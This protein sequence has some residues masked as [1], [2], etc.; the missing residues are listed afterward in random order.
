MNTD[1]GALEFQAYINNQFLFRTAKQAE[2]RIKGLADYA[3]NEAAKMDKS[4][5]GVGKTLALLGG[6]GAVS[7]LGEKI[8]ETTAKFEKFGIVLRNTLGE[9][10]GDSALAMLS[11]FAAK[12]PTQ[13]DEVTDSFIKMANQGFVPTQAE[14]IK[15]GDLSSSTGKGFGQLAEA[16]LDA[17]TNQF[18]RLKEFGITSSQ[19]QDKVTF[20]FKEQQTT[21]DKTATSIRAY[22]LSLGELNGVQGANAAI[23]ES[24][25]G[26][27]S[28]LEDRF[29][30]MYNQIGSANS[31]IIYTAIDGAST[32]VDNYEAV[33]QVVLSL[34]GIYGAYQAA[35]ITANAVSILQRE[36]A[37]QQMLAN[38]GNTGAMI[39]LTTAEGL[40]A[41]ASSAATRA[42]LALNASMLANPFVLA[43]VAV[44]SLVA[45]TYAI[46]SADSIAEQARASF[47]REQEAFSES[48]NKVSRETSSLTNIIK[49]NSSS[50][51]QQATA[52]KRLQEL[53]PDVL[54]NI[55]LHQ[56]KTMDA[57]KA[58]KEFNAAID[59]MSMANLRSQLSSF[60]TQ[61][62]DVQ[63]K[64]SAL[65]T[66]PQMGGG[67]AQYV[68]LASALER[69]R[70]ER[71]EYA[72]QINNTRRIERKANEE[73]I[74]EHQTV[75]VKNK[76]YWDAQL[77]KAKDALGK[78]DESQKGSKAWN[79]QV[80]LIKEAEGHL[81]SYSLKAAS[82]N[83]DTE[84]ITPFGTLE[85][86]NE[87]LR[88]LK[89]SVTAV[90]KVTGKVTGSTFDK[91]GK[92]TAKGVDISTEIKTA[93]AKIKELTVATKEVAIKTFDEELSYK[94]SQYEQYYMLIE[95]Y[96]IDIAKASFQSLLQ[97]GASLTS[98]LEGELLRLQAILKNGNATPEQVE[99]LTKLTTAL[100]T[101]KGVKDN[102]SI[103]NEEL[104]QIKESSKTTT[105]Y[106]EKLAAARIK[107]DSGK[108]NLTPE[109]K[110]KA[111][112]IIDKATTDSSKEALTS[113]LE[114]FKTTQTKMF[115]LEA[116]FNEDRKVLSKALSEAKTEDEK[117][118]IEAS[119]KALEV[120]YNKEKSQMSVENLMASTDWTT[121]FSD[122]DKVSV[123]K[124]IELKDK[125]EAQFKSLKLEPTDLASLR[126]KIDEVTDKIQ[127]KNPFKALS[128][129]I[130]KYKADKSEVNTKDL[131]G[132]IADSANAVK[133][134][135]DQITGSL[136]KLGVKTSEQTDVVLKD[137]SGMLGGAANL[138][139]GI[140]TGNPMAIIQGSIDLIMNGIDLIGGAA[141]RNL[142]AA[143]QQHAKE[144]V[145]LKDAYNELQRAID[146]ALGTDRYATQR[147]SIENLKKQQKEYMAMTVAEF[148]KKNTDDSKVKE[149]QDAY[150][151]ALNSIEDT[152]QKMREEILTM[153]VSSAANEL[154]NAL[155]SA[156]SA[157]EDAAKAWGAKVDDIVGN[158][159]KKML[160]QKLVEQ[161]VGAIINKY[162]STWVDSE[163]NFL[164][165]S[166]IIETAD[167]MG[168]DLKALG[169]GL[170]ASL[171]SLPDYIKN[172]LTGTPA[173]DNNTALSGAIQGVSQE[174]A[175]VISGQVNAMRIN[176]IEMKGILSAILI[177]SGRIEQNTANMVKL[178]DVVSI[179]K[180]ISNNN[181]LR[182]QG[183]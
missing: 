77:A 175:S 113:L 24:M 116:K 161:P 91:T 73:S 56:F 94:K 130:K 107:V 41:V 29:A 45:V 111:V 136:D 125:I 183:L 167:Q 36:I 177:S 13:L 14:M 182:S 134:T 166:N 83:K 152:I 118:Q 85:Y 1:N 119:S 49:D 86:W 114:K 52:F 51:L 72:L 22:L 150:K 82:V 146:S 54:K 121:L 160:I 138:A 117:R 47:R 157:G 7:M 43:T 139:M 126:S 168:A 178:N 141:D 31:G 18:E 95:N 144:V 176:Q 17:Q 10:A 84:K 124:L 147:D 103:F 169:D 132:S 140:A 99:Q 42:Q 89:E 137:V 30:A 171:G 151:A 6:V 79:E 145:K 67:T 109:E 162:L 20:T 173:V 60:D 148:N 23:S 40:L 172:Y 133:G 15:L 164:G 104:N 32:L 50:T 123:S 55:T 180:E 46:A 5:E 98:Y 127:Q 44:A 128:E 115:D 33:G 106:L 88:K 80:R 57:T 155:I 68:Q 38:I 154:G 156:F 108:S 165:F 69:L 78:I 110:T 8:I 129:A 105:E 87:V 34:V 3:V 142:E 96:G 48:I 143:I 12:T 112:Q 158:V 16:I 63:R 2:D 100:N 159:I 11:E 4:F 149:Y 120:A 93:E 75:V 28:N 102:F 81:S 76:E 35:V 66:T 37:V 39:E 19:T 21:V 174:T 181:S 53:Y 179:L 97:N 58:Q 27:L 25:T 101:A 71:R 92:V 131:F 62:A 122:L 90:D 170:S 135:F 64:I 70:A 74:K 9:K 163:G 26:K 65:S 61:I 153:D 59:E